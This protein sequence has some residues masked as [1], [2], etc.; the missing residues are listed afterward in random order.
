MSLATNFVDIL[1]HR[2][3]TQPDREAFVMLSSRGAEAGRLTYAGVDERA[4]TIAAWLQAHCAAG[5]RVLLVYPPGLEYI[6][7]FLA[8]LYAGAIAVPAYPPTRSS[9]NRGTE[10][11]HTVAANAQA[12]CVLTNQASLELVESVLQ[13]RTGDEPVRCVATDTLDVELASAWVA[14]RITAGALAFLQYTSG[15]TGDPKGVMVSHG[16][17]IENSRLIHA[18]FEHSE[19]SKGVIWLPPYHDM[20]L[21]GGILQPLYGGFSTVLMSPVSFVQRPWLWLQA[22]SRYR[23]TTSG[24][25]DFAYAQCVRQFSPQW[26]EGLDLS[27]WNVAFVGAEP[28]RRDT[29][30]RFAEC[31]APYGFDARAFYSCYGLAEATLFVTGGQASEPYRALTVDAD[32]LTMNRAQAV[33]DDGAPALDVIGCGTI[34]QA[35]HRILVVDPHSTQPVASR[36]VGE[37]WVSGPSVA[38]GYWRDAK[39]TAETFGA[40]LAN[41]DGPFM[42]TGDLGFVSD[43]ELYVTGRVKDLMIIRGR[44][45]YPHD[46]EQTVALS[47]SR[48]AQGAVAA[49]TV[50][51]QGEPEL[52]VLCEAAVSD[53]AQVAPVFAA[54][55]AAVARAHGVTVAR[56][57]FVPMRSL[58]KTTS[59]KLQR[60]QCRARYLRGDLAQL[61]SAAAPAASAHRIAPGAAP[62]R[63]IDEAAHIAA[64]SDS[65]ASIKTWMIE[66]VAQLKRVDGAQVDP[67]ASFFEL[68]L[69]SLEL[70]RLAGALGERIGREVEPAVLFEYAT[71]A[72]LAAYLRSDSCA[73][74]GAAA[75]IAEQ[76]SHD[77]RC[78]IVGISCRFPGAADPRRFWTLLADGVDAITEVPSSRWDTGRFYD[79]TPRAGRMSTRWGGFVDD[80]D[81]FDA[82]FFSI[83]PREAACADPQHRLLLELAWEALQDAGIPSKQLAGSRTGVFI[84]ISSSDY[85]H[86]QRDIDALTA[87]SATGNAHSIAANRISYYF[88]FRGPS[89]AVDTAC[90]S[91]LVALH[92]ASRSLRDGE[93]DLALV[94]GV[95]LM[96]G[97]DLHVTFSQAQMM[98]ADGRCKAFDDAADGYVRG[99]G[100]S[101]IV[102]KR[103]ADVSAQTDRWLATIRATAINQDGRSNGITAPN[104]L[105]QEDVIRTAL[106]KARID[107]RD[108]DYVEAHGTGTRLGDPVEYRALQNIF[109]VPE[110]T[111]PLLIGTVKTNIG[112]LEAAAGMAGLLKIVLSM[113]HGALPA[114]LHF[115]TLNRHIASRQARMIVCA[116]QTPWR[117]GGKARIAGVSSFGFG[118]TNCHV[119]LEEPPTVPARGDCLPAALPA[120]LTLSAGCD[121][122]LREMS[123]RFAEHVDTMP[124]EELA[125]V[126]YTTNVGRDHLPHRIAVVASDT[127]AVVTQLR[128]FAE[129]ATDSRG[130]G[131][132]YHGVA[133]RSAANVVFTFTGQGSQSPSMGRSLFERLPVFRDAMERCDALL[134]PHL[135]IP[136]LDV[137]YGDTARQALLDRTEFA[138]P[139][140]VAFEYALAQQWLALGQRPTAVLGHSL[141]EFAAACIAGALTLEDM[142]SLVAQR[143]RLMQSAPHDGMMLACC[144]DENTVRSMLGEGE[145]GVCVAAV[146]APRLIV[147]SGPRGDVERV[148]HELHR[149]GIASTPLRGQ[150]AFHWPG[151][152][153]IA[154]QFQRIAGSVR[155]L[156][157]SIPLIS[158][159]TGERVS[160]ASQLDERYWFEQMVRPVRFERGVQCAIGLGAN[161]FLEVGPDETLT[162]LGKRCAPESAAA[163]I[164]STRNR[165]ADDDSLAHALAGLYAAGAELDWRAHHAAGPCRLVSLPTYAFQRKRF[166]F[167]PAGADRRAD[168]PAPLDAQS[169]LAISNAPSFEKP[170]VKSKPPMSQTTASFIS[171][172]KSMIASLLELSVDDLDIDAPFLEMGADSLVLLNAIQAI[173]DKYGV[174]LSINQLFDETSSIRSLAAFIEARAVICAAAGE[175]G[176]DGHED[177]PGAQR[178]RTAVACAH[179]RHHNHELLPAAMA[180]PAAPAAA[181]DTRLAGLM[182]SQLTLMSEQLRLL[183][184]SSP[185]AASTLVGEPAIHIAEAHKVDPRAL[186]GTQTEAPFAWA[187][188]HASEHKAA[189]FTAWARP[190]VTTG[191]EMNETRRAHL[192]AVIER[193]VARTARSKQQTAEFRPTLADNRASA[194]FRLSTK[195]MLYPIIGKR[196]AGARMWDI[197]GNEYVDFT[198]GFGAN[199]FGHSPDFIVD[200]MSRQLADGFQ[201][202]PQSELAGIVARKL[203]AMTE[204]ER[205]A[206]CNSG[207]EAVMTAVRLARAVT[208][209]SKIALF[210]DS[211]HGTFDGILARA[212]VADGK[213]HTV[214]VAGGTPVS[215]V[216]RE[217][218]VLEYGDD[219][220]LDILRAHGH[221]L[222]AVIVEP[223]QSRHP[224][225]QPKDFLA[226]LRTLTRETSTALIF[227]EV[228][229]GFRASPG[230]A[231][232][233]FGIKADIA[234]YGKVIGGGMPI[235]V[236]AGSARFMDAIDGGAWSYGDA[237]YPRV[238]QT[239][240]AGTFNKHPLTMS[241]ALAVLE[242]LE[243]CGPALHRELNERTARLA[244]ELN[245][246]FSAEEAPL[247]IEYF[248]SLFRFAFSGNMDL[249]FYGLLA[250]GIYI[251]EGRNCFLSTAHSEEDLERFV[252]AVKDTVRELREGGHL[253]GPLRAEPSSEVALNAA[254]QRF[255]RLAIASDDEAA[256]CHIPFALRLTGELDLDALEA[257]FNEVVRRHDAL[258]AQFDI[259]RGVQRLARTADVS[260]ALVDLKAV[261]DAEK[262]AAVARWQRADVARRFDLDCAPLLRVSVLRLGEREHI[263]HLTVHHLVCD[264]MS[265]AI[266]LDEASSLYAGLKGKTQPRLAPALSFADYERRVGSDATPLRRQARLHWN[267]A[268]AESVA[269]RLPAR[270]Q[271]GL[272]LAPAAGARVRA[273]PIDGL[274]DAV[275]QLARRRRCTPFMVL[276]AA[277]QALLFERTGSER[278]TVGVPAASRSTRAGE[279]LVGNFVNLMPITCETANGDSFERLLA[280]AK[281]ELLAAYRHAQYPCPPFATADSIC[282][283]FNMEPRALAPCFGDLE[284]SLADCPVEQVEFDLMMNVNEA[285]SQYVID[286]DYRERVLDRRGAEQWLMRYQEILESIANSAGSWSIG[287]LPMDAIE[288]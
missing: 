114:S 48:C 260:V 226:K 149:A 171:E 62:A 197:D 97:P 228:I 151:L 279:V 35:G 282:A 49:F 146:N 110:R 236:I 178:E 237:S 229:T 29:L 243:R 247:R 38:G 160:G 167:A 60:A 206:F 99:E 31:F 90:S 150:H 272:A 119:L 220:S 163:F 102:L 250:R 71:I 91:S 249:F 136:L 85:A 143:G 265:L 18:R 273:K 190:P 258:R 230:G 215:F 53:S 231:Q 76:A 261:P 57:V 263:L 5:D 6:C 78:A 79:P 112:H 234:T 285:D 4:R 182:Q 103:A 7:G 94:G 164:A 165:I 214:P 216:E 244:H 168:P 45:H 3:S 17:L 20:G 74:L 180:T 80:V 175:E 207:T 238:E 162:G 177:G 271:S 280:A 211:Y 185:D 148:R 82:E 286:L 159:L 141:G 147:V 157:P 55:S 284:A 213:L 257:S 224:E 288:Q 202:G 278:L 255:A 2:A 120:V 189:S 104:G 208:R 81:R 242:K 259:A 101:F 264:G 166:W 155:H 174:A 128:R 96:L 269:N 34:D 281:A 152:A 246:Y 138:Q 256:A 153:P 277:F 25:P 204:H 43:G 127:E 158:T 194:G 50:D 63:T 266:L 172:I 105:A 142:L 124:V 52:I 98:A 183:S 75:G 199:L 30:D 196:A 22:V 287:Q 210:A 14:R 89:I 111:K 140:I 222:A 11:L 217:V 223:V 61:A 64:H 212:R 87:Y 106:E 245:E 1:R 86:L 123:A 191:E 134:K 137:L 32:A 248:S 132:P 56:L 144:T 113:E 83:T 41:G 13:G 19:H 218:V 121:A 130:R 227:D 186:S 68:G 135:P 184:R 241:A 95:N 188:V 116:A 283:T 77:D 198:M 33:S 100:A 10:R 268:V 239:F 276:F 44:N 156:E 145:G 58:P 109:D 201:L 42:R 15:S 115:R 240:F 235:G 225:R 16:N 69:D 209:R 126:C 274:Y 139:A 70:V 9:S 118:G 26:C 59:G 205:V 262:A 251:W 92:L 23:A 8:C 88:D 232:A 131:A 129:G 67:N 193:H 195:E 28:T 187:R 46:I 12:R 47:D 107:A 21:I 40:T 200:A 117:R 93:C 233:Y 122:S 173:D 65:A 66:A 252:Q 36:G 27:C 179:E 161:V 24:G 169:P 37:I 84:G 72:K 253:P 181:F 176:G 170:L 270:V 203:A 221:T 267:R 254:Q 219:A 54:A 73:P 51:R 192:Q 154:E 275:R 39:K 108:V 125:N 133:S